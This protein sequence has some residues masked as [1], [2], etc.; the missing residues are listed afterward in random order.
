M[1]LRNKSSS[2]LQCSQQAPGRPQRGLPATHGATRRCPAA[3]AST[4]TAEP[5]T[6]IKDRPD[7]TGQSN[8]ST[9]VNFVTRIPLVKHAAKSLFKDSMRKQGVDWDAFV[10]ASEATRPQLQALKEQIEDT[11]IT[12]PPY[13]LK[14]FHSY[15]DGN[16][17]WLAASV[18][19][20]HWS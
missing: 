7:W 14:D 8:L 19:E 9:I 2:M 6:S 1:H 11:A 12:Y 18:R 13:Y 20:H 4:G 15:E 17:N 3:H 10:Q 16:L 5:S